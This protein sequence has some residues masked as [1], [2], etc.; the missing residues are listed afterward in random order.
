L[1]STIATTSSNPA[2][3][4][5]DNNRQ[6]GILKAKTK[7]RKKFSKKKKK[8]IAKKK[9]FAKKVRKVMIKLGPANI[10]KEA[11]NGV[12]T[13]NAYPNTQEWNN[14]MNQTF[15]FANSGNSSG[16]F[17][18]G[19]THPTTFADRLADCSKLLDFQDNELFLYTSTNVATTQQTDRTLSSLGDAARVIQTQ[20]K[21][22]K[23]WITAVKYTISVRNRDPS[24]TI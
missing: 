7:R 1:D 18:F 15:T 23:V 3:A 2:T 5:V 13:L 8:Y 21:T 19:G 6:V 10:Y 12:F 11:C 24:A 14:F 22:G 9:K 20:G 16:G 17:W 4:V